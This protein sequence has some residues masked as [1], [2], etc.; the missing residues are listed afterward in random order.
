MRLKRSKVE[1]IHGASFGALE[2]WVHGGFGEFRLWSLSGLRVARFVFYTLE[3][4]P[5]LQALSWFKALSWFQGFRLS[6]YLI[7]WGGERG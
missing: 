4:V 3:V 7:Q 2:S 5:G 6:D 1:G